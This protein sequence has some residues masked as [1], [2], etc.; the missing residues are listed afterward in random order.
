MSETKPKIFQIDNTNL[1]K[2]QNL[3]ESKDSI[4][5]EKPQEES[6]EEASV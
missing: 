4:E 6:K 5:E 2:N 3:S 1:E